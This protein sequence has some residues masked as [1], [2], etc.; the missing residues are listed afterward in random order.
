MCLSR[1]NGKLPFRVFLAVPALLVMVSTAQAELVTDTFSR[2]NGPTFN[3]SIGDAEVPAGTYHWYEGYLIWDYNGDAGAIQSG[4]VALHSSGGAR[5]ITLNT[6]AADLIAATD[7][8]FAL[9]TGATPAANATMFLRKNTVLGGGLFWDETGLIMIEVSPTGF[10]KVREF[11]AGAGTTLYSQNP[12]T[13]STVDAF[14]AAGSLPALVNGLE[15]DDD[16]D[17][18]IGA[19]ATLETIILGAD[20]R[21]TALSVSINGQVLFSGTVAATGS[22]TG[23][24]YFALA[25]N[26][27]G[28]PCTVLT[29]FDEV[30][31]DLNPVGA[32][33][34]GT[35]VVV[36]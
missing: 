11:T 13:L 22:P 21:G 26:A 36:R 8:T 3:D 31:L 20:L 10:L 29:Y 7:V 34:T 2:A 32:S 17:G 4:K 23:N 24:N 33:L 15:F 5:Q 19:A 1:N 25:Y 18:R 16:Q 28:G 30:N 12:W 27:L 9:G 14:G 35:L 6:D